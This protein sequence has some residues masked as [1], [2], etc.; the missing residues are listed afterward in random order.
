MI[1]EDL[2]H[3][4]A[5]ASDMDQALVLLNS[6]QPFDAMFSDIRLRASVRGGYELATAAVAIRP[7]L[8]VLYTTGNTLTDD[9]RRQFVEGAA[10]LQKPYT[11]SQLQKSLQDLLAA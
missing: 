1:I 11:P 8:R 7:R 10:Y 5:Q 3:T 4:I 6:D 2:G 9:M